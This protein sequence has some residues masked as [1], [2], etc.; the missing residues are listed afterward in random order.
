MK[1]NPIALVALCFALWPATLACGGGGGGDGPSNPTVSPLAKTFD[2]D[3]AVAWFDLYYTR[4]KATGVN[5]PTASRMFGYAGVALYEA[6][7][8]GLEFH[9]SLQGQLNGFTAGTIPARPDGVYH[10]PTV[11]N[12]A[13]AVVGANFLPTSTTEIDALEDQFLTQFSSSVPADVTTRSVAYGEAVADAVLAWAATDGIATQASCASAFVA[14]VAPS[15]GGWT[16]ISPATGVGLLPCWGDLRTF[17]VS[18]SS[19]CSPAGPP[20]YSTSTSSAWYAEALLVYNTTGDAGANLSPEQLAIANY[21]SDAGTT[22]GTPPGHWIAIMCQMCGELTL[23]LDRAVE[24]FARVGIA[25]ADGFTTCWNAKYAAYRLRPE[26]Y[27]KANIDASWDPLLATPNF[28]TYVSGHA[29]QSA[30]AAT[31][32]TAMFGPIAF[33]DTTHSRLN[34]ELSLPDRAFASFQAAAAEATVSRVYGGIHYAVDDTDGADVGQCVGDILMAY[35]QF[36]HD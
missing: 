13:M 35:L 16:P 6:V 8:P 27:I 29:T 31:V 24:A 30:A 15:S 12:R 34:P 3:V 2:P 7:L 23:H 36:L 1:Q 9:N 21:W 18:N 14:P 20:A 25:V 28:P 26:T 19:E 32:L 22:T 4:V 11:A 17:V 10:W 33:T 5:P